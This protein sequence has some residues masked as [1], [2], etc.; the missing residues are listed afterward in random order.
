MNIHKLDK[1]ICNPLRDKKT[2]SL[3]EILVLIIILTELQALSDIWV[4]QIKNTNNKT[5]VIEC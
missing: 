2:L 1:N 3:F 5:I 4:T